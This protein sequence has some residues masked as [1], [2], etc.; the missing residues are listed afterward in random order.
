MS[1]KKTKLK[2]HISQPLVTAS[3]SGSSNILGDNSNSEK[4]LSS[5]KK[6]SGYF[7]DNYRTY[8]V[9]DVGKKHC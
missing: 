9:D 2:E 5:T 4:N 7:S 8:Y 3:V 6:V 1:N